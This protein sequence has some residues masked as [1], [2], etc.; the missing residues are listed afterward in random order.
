MSTCKKDSKKYCMN[1]E[2]YDYCDK[3][4]RCD[5]SCSACDDESCE[6]NKNYKEETL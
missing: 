6:N 2:H 4:N 3:A 1:C 5:G